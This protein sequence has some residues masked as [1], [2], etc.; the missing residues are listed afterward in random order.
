MGGHCGATRR[1]VNKTI[2]EEGKRFPSH[3][4]TS[5]S[6]IPGS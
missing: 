6:R 1:R 4:L 2:F 5:L 3:Q